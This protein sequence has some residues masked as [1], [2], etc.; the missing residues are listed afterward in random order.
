MKNQIK[1]VAGMLMAILFLGG[2][3]CG[4]ESSEV[5]QDSYPTAVTPHILPYRIS[6]TNEKAVNETCDYEHLQYAAD[7]WNTQTGLNLVEVVENSKDVDILFFLW[8]DTNLDWA[9]FP[10]NVV[11]M[12]LQGFGVAKKNVALVAKFIG[13]TLG[14]P[15]SED[16]ESIM[17]P[18]SAS[19]VATGDHEFEI[20]K[21]TAKEIQFVNDNLVQ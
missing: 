11:P 15:M 5:G 12:S 10:E 21:L 20:P 9:G 17:Y 16:P 6:C 7:V 2:V 3:G 8:S 1:L 19:G 13:I 14:V 4:N 18:S